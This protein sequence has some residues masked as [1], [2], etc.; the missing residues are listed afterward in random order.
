MGEVKINKRLNMVIP[1]ETDSGLN[2]WVH[3]TPI[4]RATFES[5]FDVIARAFSAIYVG[6]NG[7][8]VG[9]RVA[10]LIL[11]RVATQMGVWEGE[12][13][14]EQGLVTE[15]KRLTNVC[16]PGQNG[17]SYVPWEVATKNGT[18]NDD[19]KVEIENAL[20]FFTVAS[21]LLRKGETKA[22][23]EPALSLWGAQ[24]EPLKLTEYLASLG[25]LIVTESIGEK[26]T[27]KASSIPV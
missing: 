17:W 4:M 14:V 27:V 9:P 6:Q 10:T 20:T 13:G 22:N 18:I 16:V 21:A 25:T 3:S 23:L 5:Y 12:N 2:V 1:V 7:T 24:L 15:I 26:P 11:K 8:V 19:D